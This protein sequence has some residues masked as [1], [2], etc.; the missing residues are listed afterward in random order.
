M[1]V[2]PLLTDSLLGE[3]SS[4]SSSLE[5]EVSAVSTVSALLCPSAPSLSSSSSL[6]TTS[7]ARSSGRSLVPLMYSS[8]VSSSLSSSE[9]LDSS[10]ASL[11]WVLGDEGF[12]SAAGCFGGA[13]FFFETPTAGSGSLGL[14][15]F[16][17][18]VFRTRR[19]LSTLDASES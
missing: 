2:V 9:V 5:L 17:F 1:T 11:L 18:V 10:S 6:S 4:E 13:V 12:G 15:D 3:S 16:T 7:V 19:G 8:F 14:C